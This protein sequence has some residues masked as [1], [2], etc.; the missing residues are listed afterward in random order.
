MYALRSITVIKWHMLSALT[1][2]VLSGVSCDFEQSIDSI[3][4]EDSVSGSDTRSLADSGRSDTIDYDK[5][6]D[7]QSDE[8]ACLDPCEFESMVP[9]PVITITEEPPFA[10]GDVIHASAGQSYHCS[11]I[12]IVAWHWYITGPDDIEIEPSPNNNAENVSFN[13]PGPGKHWI[14]LSVIDNNGVPSCSYLGKSILA[15]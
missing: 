4:S 5:Y 3:D 7:E 8:S 10:V 6:H 2:V 1:L 11:D 13:L 9:V 14:Y 12:P 15:E